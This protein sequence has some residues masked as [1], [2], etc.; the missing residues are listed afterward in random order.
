VGNPTRR[1]PRCS[2]H[3]S[4]SCFIQANFSIGRRWGDTR[5]AEFVDELEPGFGW[6]SPERPRLRMASHALVADGGVWLIDPA[7][8][9]GVEERVR[10]LGEPAG[11]LQLLDRHKRACAE[12]ARRLGVPHRRVPFEQVG[13]F[14]TIPIVRRRVWHEVALWW[15]ERRVLVCADAL[16]TVPHYF[17]LDG[18]RLGVHPLLRLTPP[19]RLAALDPEHVLCGHG[20][21]VH[22]DATAALRE[23]L[24]HSRRRAPRVLVE[25]WRAR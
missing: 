9:D 18:E 11:V 5:I 13:P 23:A 1:L 8:A 24:D 3:Y 6:L 12:F 15:P 14:Q 19:R 10:A 20:S 7:E 22:E 21:G 16:G 2:L 25:W 17:A 4:S